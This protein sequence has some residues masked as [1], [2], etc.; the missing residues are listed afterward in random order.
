MFFSIDIVCLQ[1]RGSGINIESYFLSELMT[2]PPPQTPNAI[3]FRQLS[4]Y[5]GERLFHVLWG[6]NECHQL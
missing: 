4:I 3:Q 2:H 1:N 5:N 6:Q